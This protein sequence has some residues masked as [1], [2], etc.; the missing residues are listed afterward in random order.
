MRLVRRFA[1]VVLALAITT[2]VAPAAHAGRPVRNN[3]GLVLT[4]EAVVPGPGD[5]HG[6]G[7]F[8][9]S[10]GS[11]EVCYEVALD[12]LAGFVD[13]IA[14][15]RGAAGSVGPE[16]ALLSP[17]PQGIQGLWGCRAIDRTL[18]R[19]ISR[20]PANFYML[21][22]TSAYPGGALRGQLRQ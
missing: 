6:S 19:E 5:A 12:G 15:H 4:A 9:V 11:N 18:A 7:T 13:R 16:V 8:K 2:V 3:N 10:F 1:F 14:I 17:S 22:K 21:V 20:T